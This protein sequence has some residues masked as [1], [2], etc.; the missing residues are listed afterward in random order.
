ML[1]KLSRRPAAP[2][3]LGL[4][5]ICLGASG[6]VRLEDRSPGAEEDNP[7]AGAGNTAGVPPASG[8]D[9]SPVPSPGEEPSNTA[10][11]S[12]D[13]PPVGA[14]VENEVCPP[15]DRTAMSTITD[16]WDLVTA[17]RGVSSEHT[18]MIQSLLTNA[19]EIDSR[20]VEPCRGKSE[21]SIFAEEVGKLLQDA[22][23]TGE[24]PGASYETVADAG[25]DLLRAVDHE[26]YRF[27][28]A[29][30]H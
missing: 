25:N 24:A 22:Q 27:T 16:G 2:L 3:A 11:P 8:G 18:D 17:S 14:E 4:A 6:C 10:G 28:P 30:Q 19:V 7:A 9:Q 13:A 21:I 15:L 29:Y 5:M 20:T 1:R 12:E 26:G 23:A